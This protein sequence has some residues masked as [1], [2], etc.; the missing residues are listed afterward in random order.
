MP[1]S[2][3][4]RSLPWRYSPSESPS[5]C[6]NGRAH[7][8]RDR[9]GA[10]AWLRFALMLARFAVDIFQLAIFGATAYLALF[11]INPGDFARISALAFVNA[12]IL[13]RAILASARAM[14]G[15]ETSTFRPL[16][17][18]DETAGYWFVWLRRFVWLTVY[19]YALADSA[20]LLG[21]PGAAYEILAKIIGTSIAI[22]L[23]ILILQNRTLTASWIRGTP[24]EGGSQGLYVLRSRFAD[25]W[26][27]LA[28]LYVIAIFGIWALPIPGGFAFIARASFVSVVLLLLAKA[29]AGGGDSMLRSFFSIGRD[30]KLRFPGLQKRA[31]RY[32][33]ILVV[34][35]HCV[36]YVGAAIFICEAWG[37]GA[38]D[39]MRSDLGR[40]IIGD[41]ATILV[42]TIVAAAIWEGASLLFEYYLYRQAGEDKVPV[43]PGRLRTLLPLIRRAIAI[44]LIIFVVLIALSELGVNIAPLLAGAGVIG[45]AVGFGAQGFVKD[46]I[47]GLN[48]LLEDTFGVGDVV[49]IGAD[50]G[51]VEAI[52][53]RT[54]RLRD[55]A[56]AL[57]TIP[58]GEVTKVT[59]SSRDYGNA[60]FNIPVGFGEDF[61]TVVDALNAVG[62]QM[63][64]DP[65]IA[66]AI[67]GPLQ[68]GAGSLRR[69][70]DDRANADQD[71]AGPA[72]RRGTRIQPAPEGAVRRIGHRNALSFPP[73]ICRREQRPRRAVCGAAKITSDYFSARR[74]GGTCERRGQIAPWPS[75]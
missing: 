65:A 17:M 22:L 70:R 49:T 66:W 64:K 27:V 42:T 38:F 48:L 46:L 75:P 45:I 28:L 9:E 34:S 24:K 6:C 47:T 59:N 44:V 35:L 54:M 31:D 30:L 43:R 2:N 57:H 11:L 37:L 40:Q 63:R 41:L 25:I 72:D 39:W 23:V 52:T 74:C 56:G 4:S 18:R 3:S 51:V 36:L 16:R 73:P 10:S 53:M 33:P 29:A 61:D 62:V 21:L 8:I 67:A 7:S 26:H 60:I 14:L 68:P 58:F 32:L 15:T 13:V 5:S 19:G 69:L 20:L 1:R 50:S 55:G 71:A 12:N